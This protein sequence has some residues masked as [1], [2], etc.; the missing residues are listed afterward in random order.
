M[1]LQEL[2]ERSGRDEAG[3]HIRSGAS[4]PIRSRQRAITICVARTSAEPERLR[5]ALEHAVLVVE[6][7]EVVGDADRVRRQR[8]RPAPLDRLRDDA[9]EL[10]EPLDQLALLRG[11]LLRRS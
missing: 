10:G 7:V 8:L 4:T 3:P 9:G 5:L 1:P 2:R 6:A 11:E